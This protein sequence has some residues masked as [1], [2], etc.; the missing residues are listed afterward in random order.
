[1]CLESVADESDSAE[2][3]RLVENHL[4]Y[5]G[6]TVAQAL[7]QDWS[8][9]IEKF[10]KV[11]PVDYKRVLEQRAADRQQASGSTTSEVAKV[12]EVMASPR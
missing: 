4:E 7:L 10:V 6:S 8:T 1:M 2:L 5:T 11:M 12:P 9:S 3:R